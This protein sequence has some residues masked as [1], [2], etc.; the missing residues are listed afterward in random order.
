MYKNM[1][2]NRTLTIWRGLPG[3][4]K[5]TLASHASR[6]VFEADQ[7]FVDENGK[8]NFNPKKLKEAHQWCLDSVEERMLM[9][10]E[11]IHVANT[12]TQKWEME[13]YRSLAASH[14]YTVVIKHVKGDW[15]S[16]HNVPD[17][18]IKKMKDRWEDIEG[19]NIILNLKG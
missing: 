19:E 5:S 4:G 11:D 18:S 17:A 10:T 15:G 6:E 2:S 1:N 3:S 12:F 8:Y 7:Y 9:L 13:P 16:I 14:G